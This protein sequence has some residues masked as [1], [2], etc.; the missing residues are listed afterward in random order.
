MDG[1]HPTTESAVFLMSHNM[2]WFNTYDLLKDGWLP[3]KLL[4]LK[5]YIDSSLRKL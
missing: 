4:K 1:T 3:V 5:Y 2:N